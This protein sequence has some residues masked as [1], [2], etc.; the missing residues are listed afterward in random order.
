MI[1]LN[2]T[3]DSMEVE[4]GEVE[5]ENQVPNTNNNR[6]Q[7]PGNFPSNLPVNHYFN[8]HQIHRNENV[9]IIILLL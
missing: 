5:N 4:I 6:N 1:E 8:W 2:E 9:L 3:T 7:Q